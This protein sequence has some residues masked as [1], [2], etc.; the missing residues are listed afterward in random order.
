MSQWSPRLQGGSRSLVTHPRHRRPLTSSLL[1]ATMST[2]R[3]AHALVG[4]APALV[5]ARMINETLYCERLT[6]LEWVQGEFADN[7]YTIEGRYAHR[8]ADQPGGT[9]PEP[10]EAEERPYRARSVWLSS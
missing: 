7:E 5:P 10:V 2:T 3:E 1:E 6:Y 4:E 9:L 8:R